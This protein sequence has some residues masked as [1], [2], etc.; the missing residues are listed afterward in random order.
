MLP[1]NSR[2]E[3]HHAFSAVL[4]LESQTDI[5][6]GCFSVSQLP[7]N[8]SRRSTITM[9]SVQFTAPSSP[10]F[11]TLLSDFTTLNDTKVPQNAML[12]NQSVLFLDSFRSPIS[13][14]RALVKLAAQA[15][16]TTRSSD[17]DY[18][19]SSRTSEPKPK[20]QKRLRVDD[21][22]TSR[23]RPKIN[24]LRKPKTSGY[25]CFSATSGEPVTTVKRSAFTEERKAEVNHVRMRG[26]CLRCQIRKIPVSSSCFRTLSQD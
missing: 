24:N 16:N 22:H 11:E 18:Q 4:S 19:P 23:K 13:P 9:E 21:F 12:D 14:P 25:L 3:L 15:K 5:N 1:I 2:F 20:S 26:A 8:I 6:R 10:N 17:C 7:F